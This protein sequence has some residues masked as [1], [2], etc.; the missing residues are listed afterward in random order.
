M[1]RLI[2]VLGL[3]VLCTC[4]PLPS[5]EVEPVVS[6][7]IEVRFSNFNWSNV[8]LYMVES[9]RSS[10]RVGSSTSLGTT[11]FNVQFS[12]VDEVQF[13]VRLAGSRDTWL[14]PPISWLRRDPC[15]VIRLENHLPFTSVVP[16]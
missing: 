11:S 2:A 12:G 16:C 3:L 4:A 6:N 5:A 13:F 15:V 10:R 14:S 8:R 9:G 1:K 7:R